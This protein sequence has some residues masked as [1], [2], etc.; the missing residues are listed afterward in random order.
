MTGIRAILWVILLSVLAF[1]Q[2]KSKAWD[3]LTL[4]ADTYM[5][6]GQYGKALVQ[7]QKARALDSQQVMLDI[8]IRECQF[9]LGTWVPGQD[10]TNMAWIEVDKLRLPEVPIKSFDSL[11]RVAKGLEERESYEIAL[12]ILGHLAE[13][14]PAKNEYV[15]AYQSLRI[16]MDQMVVNHTEVGEV[17]LK[18]GRFS[19]AREE[20]RR[21]LFF[22]PGDPFVQERLRLV[23]SK[24]SEMLASYRSQLRVALRQDEAEAS[25]VL[26]DRAFRDFPLQPEFKRAAD[27]LRQVHASKKEK[28]LQDCRTMITKGEIAAAEAKLREALVQ[29]PGEPAVVQLQMEAQRLLDGQKRNGMRDSLEKQFH[30][31]IQSGNLGLGAMQL[32]KLRT[33]FPEVDYSKQQGILDQ[34]KGQYQKQREFEGTLESARRYMK[35]GL[36]SQAK[37]ALQTALAMQPE[38]PVAK[39]M[40]ADLQREEVR[41]VAIEEQRRKDLQRAEALVAAGQIQSAKKVDLSL[42]GVGKVDQEVKQVQRTIREA[43]FARTPEKDRRAQELFLEGIGKYRVGDYEEALEKWKLTLKL[44]PDHDQAK[45]YVANVKQK[46]SRMR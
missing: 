15:K 2:A 37:E 11:F 32:Q 45:K 21:A 5:K 27:S 3:Q 10:A 20:F 9:R 1:A 19:E 25:L 16:R 6:Q 31:A 13:K 35:D 30:Q 12:K 26:A 36:L 34:K 41:S 39:Q 42:S 18:Q 38:S 22:R 46:L 7:L 24:Q 40:L 14:A 4:D 23:E 17:F 43:E 28:V 29:F 33:E 8:K 44:N